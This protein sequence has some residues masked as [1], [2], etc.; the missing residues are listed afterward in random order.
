MKIAPKWGTHHRRSDK[1]LK[2]DSTNQISVLVDQYKGEPLKFVD[3]LDISKE[4]WSYFSNATQHN[5]IVLENEAW[6]QRASGA[7]F[8]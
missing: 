2:L 4:G 3:D 1:G 8:A 5:P 7:I 6:E